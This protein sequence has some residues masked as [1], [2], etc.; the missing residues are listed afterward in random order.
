MTLSIG[1]Q[2]KEVREKR[3]LTR[4][5]ASKATH[6]KPYYIEA[7]EENRY[8]DIPSQVQVK[9]FI[10]LYADWLGL[11]GQSL[12]DSMESPESL[13]N[14]VEPPTIQDSK[15]VDE[16]NGA[17]LFS[18]FTSKR[19]KKTDSDPV[20]PDEIAHELVPIQEFRHNSA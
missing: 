9:G 6:I 8:E 2:L 11:P 7:L 10:R 16:K 13:I 14:E 15:D 1:E 18:R 12:L 20:S 4:E 19:R 17:S 5:E 3:G